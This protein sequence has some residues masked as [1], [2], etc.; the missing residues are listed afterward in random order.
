MRSKWSYCKIALTVL[1]LVFIIWDMGSGGISDADIESVTEQVVKAAGMEEMQPAGGRM[2]KRF[3][4][5]NPNDYAGVVL[6]A[7]A[8]NMD[9][10]ELL[11]VKMKDVSQREEVEEAIEERL[12]TQLKSFEGY[13]PEQTALLKSHV[14]RVEGNYVF[15]MV[16]ERAQ[17]AGSAFVK[18]L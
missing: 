10:R 12:D 3:Y 9:A 5:L 7:P 6:Y 15:Y 16:H 17:E 18:S 1:L 4:G 11:I 14:L 2:V 13:G 8:D